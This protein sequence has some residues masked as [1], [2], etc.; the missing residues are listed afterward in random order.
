MEDA[1]ATTI[2]CIIVAGGTAF[3][4][5]AIF[6]LIW[7]RIKQRFDFA[8]RRMDELARERDVWRL[9]Y[10]RLKRQTER[11]GESWKL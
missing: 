7:D 3:I 8:Y 5:V 11:D 1:I 2:S 6:D 10:K 9:R 4:L